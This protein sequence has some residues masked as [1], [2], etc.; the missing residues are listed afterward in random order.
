MEAFR[1]ADSASSPA[2][3]SRS[4]EA[5][6]G[7][8]ARSGL[9]PT[10]WR[11]WCRSTGIHPR[12]H[13]LPF[14][15]AAERRHG[16]CTATWAF[17]TAR[18]ATR[19]AKPSAAYRAG[20]L[21]PERGS[22]RGGAADSSPAMLRALPSCC[23]AVATTAVPLPVLGH[24]F[25][26]YWLTP[27]L[28]LGLL[29]LADLLVGKAPLQDRTSRPHRR[30]RR[31]RCCSSTSTPLRSGA[32]GADRLGSLIVAGGSLSAWRA[33]SVSIGLVTGGRHHGWCTSSAIAARAPTGRSRAAAAGDGVLRPIPSEH[34]RGHH[35]R[36]AARRPVY[37]TLRQTLY[38]FLPRAPVGQPR[39][40]WRLRPNGWTAVACRCSACTTRCCG[41]PPRRAHRYRAVRALGRPRLVPVLRR[42]GCC[43]FRPAPGHP[44]RRALRPGGAVSNA[45]RL[46]RVDARHSWNA[47]ERLSNACL[48][49]LQRH[50]DHQPQPTLPLLRDDPPARSC[51]PAYP[52]MLLLALWL[53]L[54]FRIMN[55]R[56][57]HW[58]A[59]CRRLPAQLRAERPSSGAAVV[60]APP[61]CA[62]AAPPALQLLAG[63]LHRCKEQLRARAVCV[64]ADEPRCASSPP[65]DSGRKAQ[66]CP[67]RGHFVP[68]L[69]LEVHALRAR[70]SP[71]RRV[72]SSRISVLPTWASVGGRPREVA[73]HRRHQRVVCSASSVKRIH[74]PTPSVTTSGQWRAL[75][76]R[77]SP[78]KLKSVKGEIT[79]APPGSRSPSSHSANGVDS[80][81]RRP[82]DRRRSRSTSD[83]CPRSSKCR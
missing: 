49:N 2:A 35:A 61:A 44:L 24:P 31:W 11:V 3:S 54:W 25:G 65:L 42:P 22:W 39:S 59:P 69:D 73:E 46:E 83:R 4:C 20:L 30:P 16:G 17:A 43:R 10:R 53:P 62:A 77:D 67:T 55:P 80:V 1:R 38:A 6:W 57:Q 28:A 51:R 7:R 78:P 63:S 14:A 8:A 47:S 5:A 50:A 56:V 19:C 58:R 26:Q 23:F 29:P 18:P 9:T 13:G 45:G 37:R 21:S 32:P 33:L 40:A 48:F 70:R 74:L 81:S 66:T 76:K 71:T 60:R 64:L 27:W 79:T 68:H 15:N 82:P 12:S 34:N 75:A 41:S 52:G 36:V 72:S